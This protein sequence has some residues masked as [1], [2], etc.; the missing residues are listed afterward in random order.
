MCRQH[1]SWVGLTSLA[2]LA[3]PAGC[4]DDQPTGD[5]G[6]SSTPT[7]SSS[8]GAGGDTGHGGSTH[9]GGT[10]PDGGAGGQGGGSLGDI[11]L[12]DEAD[13]ACE[14]TSAQAIELYAATA[15][16]PGYDR[17]AAVGNRWMATSGSYPTGFV[18]FDAAGANPSAAPLK[19]ADEYNF[20]ASEGSSIAV[21]GT[22]AAQILFQRYD[23]AD[24]LVGGPLLVAAQEP[25]NLAIAGGGGE[26]IIVWGVGTNMRARA[27]ASNGTFAGPT[28]GFGPGS[29]DGYFSGAATYADP[30]F[31]VAWTGEVNNTYVTSF[32]LLSTTGVVG[33]EVT[34]L[35]TDMAHSVV[36]IAKRSPGYALLL[37]VDFTPWRPVLVMIGDDGLVYGSGHGLL[38]ASTGFDL[39]ARTADIG[40]V[41]KRSSGETQF[42]SF[43]LN[44]TAIGPWVCLNG[45]V[46]SLAETAAIAPQSTGF[47]IVYRTDDEAE[48][49]IEVDSLGSI[50]P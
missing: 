5:G 28:F 17:L 41:A 24:G 38:G 19:H 21:V 34:V 2:L 48:A 45:S 37:N 33:A 6:S 18:T 27:V 36:K 3:A 16:P 20:A 29:I 10:R 32:A 4:G 42:R 15:N 44:G 49:F 23:D 43:D 22:T 31:A 40:V 39:A 11:E 8:G 26:S 35:S 25:V 14:A 7:S 13:T 50:A 47:A 46:V 1:L 12:I 30:G 9:E